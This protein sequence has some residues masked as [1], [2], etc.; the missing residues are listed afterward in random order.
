[1]GQREQEIKERLDDFRHFFFTLRKTIARISK[2]PDDMEQLLNRVEELERERLGL[3]EIQF[4]RGLLINY[5]CH[6]NAEQG[7]MM[8]LSK[9]I[10]SKIDKMEYKMDNATREREDIGT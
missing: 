2:L 3:A 4:I 6:S 1:M 7:E 10:Q 9:R 8:D 5:Q